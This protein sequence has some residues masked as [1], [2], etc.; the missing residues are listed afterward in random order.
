MRC[1]V[2]TFSLRSKIGDST[3]HKENFI[4]RISDFT[5]YNKQI[6]YRHKTHKNIIP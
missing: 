4:Y 1:G 3:R 6:Q 5:R 2:P